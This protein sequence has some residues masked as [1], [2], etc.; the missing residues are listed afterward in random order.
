MKKIIYLIII[1]F[2]FSNL[3]AQARLTIENNSQRQMKSKDYEK[4]KCFIFI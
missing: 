3:N 2:A 1:L 4:G